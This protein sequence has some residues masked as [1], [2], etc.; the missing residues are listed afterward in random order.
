MPGAKNAHRLGRIFRKHTN[1]LSTRDWDDSKTSDA[2]EQS[3]GVSMSAL[4]K[5]VADLTEEEK[6][7]AALGN[8]PTPLEETALKKR[9][10]RFGSAAT[11]TEAST[12]ASALPADPEVIKRRMERFGSGAAGETAPAVSVQ[13]LTDAMKRRMERFGSSAVTSDSSTPAAPKL[14][15]EEQAA[16]ERRAKRF[17]SQQ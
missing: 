12:P 11:T 7:V 3:F 5:I 13:E 2:I 9:M 4:K 15:E 17:A 14:S 8:D 6:V 10:E 16:L 1:K